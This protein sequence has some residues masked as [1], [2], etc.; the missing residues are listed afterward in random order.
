MNDGL[1]VDCGGSGGW[2][3]GFR[4]NNGDAIDLFGRVSWLINEK[5]ATKLLVTGIGGPER[6]NNSDD[7][8][9][10]L[11]VIFTTNLSDQLTLVLNGDYGW[12]ENAGINREDG[13]RDGRA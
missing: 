9:Y 13:S 4:D 5:S 7:Y 1:T 10:V 8:R 12:E 2:E 6:A 11:D 3:Q